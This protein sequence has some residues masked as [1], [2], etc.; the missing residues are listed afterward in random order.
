MSSAITT[1]FKEKLGLKDYVA[2]GFGD[3]AINFTFGSL[4]M[5]VVY[6]YTDI[7]G[8]SAAAVGTLMLISRSFD[9]IIDVCVGTLVDK[10]HSRWGKARPWLL[11]GA[12]PFGILTVTLF[13]VPQNASD[14]VKI[15]YIFISYNLLMIA[16][17]SMAIPYGTLNSLVTQ[18]QGQREKLNL[19]RMFLAQ[20]GIL[21]IT[22][23]TMPLVNA[24]GGGQMGWVLAYAV[25]SVIAC[26]LF[27]V[28]FGT[29][30]ERVKIAKGTKKKSQYPFK[31]EVK[32]WLKNKY[33]FM[34]FGFLAFFH[35][36]YS[37]TQGSLVYYAKYYLHQPDAVGVLT[38]AYLLPAMVGILA[39]TKL[40]PKF[41]KT[42][43]V[44]FCLVV[45][46]I[47]YLLPLFA[48]ESY[49]FIVF[50]QVVKG[51]VYG[52]ILGSIW[53]FFPDTIEYGYWKTKIRVEGLL[54]SGGS[55]GQKIGL[56]IGTAMVG[57]VLAAGGYDG[58]KAVQSAGAM[59]AIDM[60]Y[61]WLPIIFFVVCIVLMA[62][63]RIDKIFPKIMSDLAEWKV[64]G[65]PAPDAEFQ[66]LL[67]E[68]DAKTGDK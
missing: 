14:T 2:Y 60:I 23:A 13:A 19:S 16:F 5:F 62:M 12:I 34:A 50:T 48:K 59:G 63:Y 9:G 61:V 35:V 31:V 55:L 57:W 8:I 39:C 49:S 17:S 47:A 30:K 21:I 43:V 22:N 56:G 68:A 52:P 38:L 40:F 44:I 33:W 25:L 10:T 18:D 3:M 67:D 58:A 6:F 42:K 26:L 45:S 27:W 20:C 1:S 4:G 24:F 15:I 41:G 54:Y 37:L 7:V 65:A 51:I 32:A 29:Q 36:A 46:I 11:F 64:N 28:V 53:A 66:K